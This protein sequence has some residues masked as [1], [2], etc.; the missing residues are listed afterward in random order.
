MKRENGENP[1]QGRC[2]DR[3]GPEHLPLWTLLG[4][5]VPWEGR[6]EPLEP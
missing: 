4:G 2:C 6:S 1:L 3:R 5:V